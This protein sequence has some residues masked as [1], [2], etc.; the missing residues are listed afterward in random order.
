MTDQSWFIILCGILILML[1]IWIISRGIKAGKSNKEQP[2]LAARFSGVRTD[3]P[4][5]VPRGERAQTQATS[6]QTDASSDPMAALDRATASLEAT[7]SEPAPPQAL[8]EMELLSGASEVIV[9]TLLPKQL[10]TFDGSEVLSVLSA[11]GFKYGEMNLFH[12]YGEDYLYSV[13]RYHAADASEGFDLQS[14]QDEPIDG[15]TFIMPLPHP[16][17]V[18]AAD[19]LLSQAASIAR[20]LSASINTENLSPLGRAER[21]ALL[22]Q[23]KRYH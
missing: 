11:Y 23:A 7:A 20:D 2:N 13:M 21:E 15:L 5:V 8:S 6:N 16:R 18:H 4:P 3:Q 12:Q 9:I 10:V 1:G 14:M 17:S 19:V 22:N